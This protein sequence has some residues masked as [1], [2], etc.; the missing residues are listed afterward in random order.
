MV[1]TIESTLV[2]AFCC[3]Q[4]VNNHLG[5]CAIFPQITAFVNYICDFSV[6]K[7]DFLC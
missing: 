5:F 2:H 3:A 1:I 7:R 4:Q 6:S